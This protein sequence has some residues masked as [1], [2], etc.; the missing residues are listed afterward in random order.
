LSACCMRC[1]CIVA[2]CWPVVPECRRLAELGIAD[3]QI[4]TPGTQPML[5][6]NGR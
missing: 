3:L 1:E 6:C 2:G 4:G 5:Y